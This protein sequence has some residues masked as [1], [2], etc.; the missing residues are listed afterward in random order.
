MTRRH[1]RL[2]GVLALLLSPFLSAPL[3]AQ[4]QT[5]F[6]AAD[7]GI[8]EK[9]GALVPL[10]LTLAD[11]E[12]KP[13]QLRSLIDRPTVLT[14]NYF[15]CAGI[16]TLLLNGVAD[17]INGTQAVPGKEFRVI[18]V[19]F[20]PRDTPDIAQQKR[21]NYLK[22]ITRPFPPDAWR[23][24]TGPR[25]STKAL[26]DAVGFKFKPQGD[27]F[28][29]PGAILFLSPQGVVTRY[30]YGVKYLP[31]DFQIAVLEASRGEVEPT[32]SKFL[33]ICFTYD[34]Q[35]RRYVLNLTRLVGAVTLLAVAAFAVVLAR[36]GRRHRGS[37]A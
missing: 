21:A 15:R 6:T 3:N 11:E 36:S 2:V 7:V 31:A 16:C 34:P 23:F 26:C 12:G 13:V 25:P 37:K 8:D 32:I 28:I 17:V 27:D 30:M 18:T 14:L 4:D 24:L 33:S 9:L 22:E 35:G 29:H 1:A 5:S 19:S 20:D 10:D